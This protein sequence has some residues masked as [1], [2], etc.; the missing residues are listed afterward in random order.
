[1]AEKN[2]R[3]N[4][5]I[6]LIGAPTEVGAGHRGGAMGPEALR[7]AGLRRALRQI[8]QTVVDQGDVSGP[9]NPDVAP[10]DGYRHLKEVAAWCGAVRDAVHKALGDG[11]FPILLGGDHCLAIGSIAGIAK[12]CAEREEACRWRSLRDMGPTC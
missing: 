5:K 3:N 7:V 10:V 11:L 12:H 1:M 8:G 2:S 6:A 4:P 9:P